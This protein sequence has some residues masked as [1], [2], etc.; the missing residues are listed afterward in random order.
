[1]PWKASADGAATQREGG[2]GGE[3]MKD[4]IPLSRVEQERIQFKTYI[5][6]CWRSSGCVFTH[7]V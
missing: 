2:G 7:S 6:A 3:W 1:M 5:V 4:R